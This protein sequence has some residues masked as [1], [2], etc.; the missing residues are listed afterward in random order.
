MTASVV[1]DAAGY[2]R[3][4]IDDHATRLLAL[5]DSSGWWL[6]VR[7]IGLFLVAVRC[8]GNGCRCGVM[9][10]EREEGAAAVQCLL[11]SMS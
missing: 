1:F 10:G 4:N 11:S 6:D 5:S 9:Q 7:L 3:E 8:R 2:A